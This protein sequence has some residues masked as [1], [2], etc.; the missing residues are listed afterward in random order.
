MKKIAGFWN[1]P[2]ARTLLGCGH[3]HQYG[4]QYWLILVIEI[5]GPT[6]TDEV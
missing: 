4:G 2:S 1:R 5:F 6:V 3:Q